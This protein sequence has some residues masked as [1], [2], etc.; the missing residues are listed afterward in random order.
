TR[1][2]GSHPRERGC[3]LISGIRSLE[4]VAVGGDDS[5][6]LVLEQGS[7]RSGGGLAILGVAAPDLALVQSSPGADHSQDQREHH[8]LGLVNVEDQIGDNQR[9]ARA[10][11]KYE[12]VE[13]GGAG[14]L[15]DL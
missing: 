3:E 11:K 14:D 13:L 7:N 4:H 9:S 10:V 6:Q 8:A 1:G 12:F 5:A 2:P 15:E